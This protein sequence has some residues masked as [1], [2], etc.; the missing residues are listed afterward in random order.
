[1]CGDGLLWI[2]SG[3]WRT[4]LCGAKSIASGSVRWGYGNYGRLHLFSALSRIWGIVGWVIYECH[5]WK[6]LD[7][8]EKLAWWLITL[9]DVCSTAKIASQVT[10]MGFNQKHIK[11]MNNVISHVKETKDHGLRYHALDISSLGSWQSVIPLLPAMMIYLCIAAYHNIYRR[12]GTREH[13][14]N[15]ERR[16]KINLA[17]V[18]EP[19]AS[20]RHEIDDVGWIRKVD[21]IADAFTQP[22]CN[23]LLRELMKSGTFNQSVWQWV[24]RDDVIAEE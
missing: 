13:I 12:L 4:I 3:D 23:S 20:D 22:S 5:L 24:I 17:A 1:M 8:T 21:N 11:S 16:L 14:K 2:N 19:E 10:E 9:P 7:A 18:R 15:S 6:V